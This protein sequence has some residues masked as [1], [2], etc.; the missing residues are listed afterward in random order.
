VSG[1]GGLER[2]Y[3]RL[4]AWYPAEHRRRYGEEMIGVLM[5]AAPDGA[6]RPGPAGAADLVRRGIQARFRSFARWLAG[7]SWPDALAVCSVAVPVILASYFTAG[8]LREVIAGVLSGYAYANPVH[9]QVESGLIVAALA[10]PPLLGLR[11]RRTA[12]AVSLALAGWY[13][14]IV[15][16]SLPE[17]VS[18]MGVSG[19]GQWTWLAHG[20][21]LSSWL[22]LL[23]GAAALAWSPGPRR[24][25]QL[26]GPASWLTLII[27]GVVMGLLQSYLW[28]RPLWLVAVIVIAALAA[29]AAA[30]MLTLPGRSARGLILLLAVPAYPGAVW[31]IGYSRLV[32]NH[33][34]GFSFKILFA[35]TV[36]IACLATAAL[37]RSRHRGAA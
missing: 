26:L 24:G 17:Y 14:V 37:W 22:A 3:R 15:F 18:Y 2:R 30:L 13:A 11:W 5:A 25:A 36:L 20:D 21:G 23:L 28:V 10:A 34:S 27:P 1:A 32:T 6:D 4:L 29:A 33:T 12:V 8:W 16:G 7:T 19:V 9:V 35:P 31:A